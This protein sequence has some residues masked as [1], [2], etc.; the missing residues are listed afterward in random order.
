MRGY[1][2]IFVS[3]CF[4]CGLH[5]IEVF[6]YYCFAYTGR[7]VCARNITKHKICISR[8]LVNYIAY[9]RYEIKRPAYT[10]IRVRPRY[11]QTKTTGENIVVNE[12]YAPTNSPPSFFYMLY[13]EVYTGWI[14]TNAQTNVLWA[15]H[16][17][18]RLT[19]HH[20][21]AYIGTLLLIFFFGQRH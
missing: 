15:M 18:M 21:R 13:R 11:K 6:I 12:T 17:F 19:T 14:D 2:K 3:V 10:C 4:A 20:V 9:T 7:Y 16:A 5:S 8:C 1:N